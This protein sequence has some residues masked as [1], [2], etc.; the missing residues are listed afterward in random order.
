MPVIRRMA[1][2]GDWIIGMGGAELKATGRCIYAMKVTRSMTFDQY[3]NG[4]EFFG[5]RPVRHGSRRTMVGDN[6]YRRDPETK[7]WLQEDCVHSQTSGEQEMANTSHDTKTD[8]V[9]ISDEFYYFGRDAPVV[10]SKLLSKVGYKNGRGHR[11]FSQDDCQ[12]LLNWIKSEA[13]YSNRVLA[14]PFQFRQSEKRFSKSLN[15]LIS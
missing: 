11:V 6:V 15:K 3:W 4:E 8:R 14:E 12:P 2:H 7:A 10:P 13:K 1:S 9:L 5:K